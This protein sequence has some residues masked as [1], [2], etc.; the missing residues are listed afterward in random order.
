MG[1]HD[2]RTATCGAYERHRASCLRTGTPLTAG[3]AACYD[4]IVKL[5]LRTLI[6]W[7]VL[8]AVPFQGLATA[9]MLPCAGCDHAAAGGHQATDTQQAEPHH[10]AAEPATMHG[11]VGDHHGKCSNCADSCVGAA[12]APSGLPALVAHAP[13]ALS[14]P[15]DAG[16]LSSVDLDHPER[17]PRGALA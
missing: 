3:A 16:P 8:L 9:A 5:I 10:G 11:G 15:F 17:P 4:H 13:A 1:Y 12:I 7:L 6:L 2:I 14:I